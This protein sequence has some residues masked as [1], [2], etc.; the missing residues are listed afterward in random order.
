MDKIALALYVITDEWFGG[1]FAFAV[2]AECGCR[3]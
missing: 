2:E 1:M 3:A